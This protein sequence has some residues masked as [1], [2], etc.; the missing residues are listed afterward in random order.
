[1][2]IDLEGRTPQ[3]LQKLLDSVKVSDLPVAEKG[4]LIE[5]IE[6]HLTGRRY[7]DRQVLEDIEARV[8]EIDYSDFK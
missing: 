8:A 5:E 4:K 2:K 3:Q 1:M 6:Y 7:T